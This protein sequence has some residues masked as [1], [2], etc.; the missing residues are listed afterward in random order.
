VALACIDGHFKHEAVLVAVDEY[1]LYLLEV[2]AL[3][4]FFPQFLPASAKVRGIAGLNS[5]IKRLAVHI[6]D[7]QDLS[8]PGILS[9]SCNQ[10]I[11]VEFWGEFRTLLDILPCSHF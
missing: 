11:L 6:A 7:H 9:H 10:T 2:P 3:L 5:Q 8:G 4:A 1:L